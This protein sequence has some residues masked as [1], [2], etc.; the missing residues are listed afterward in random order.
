MSPVDERLCA[1]CKVNPV[2]GRQIFCHQ[3]CRQTAFRLRQRGD[4]MIAA[5]MGDQV[6][7]YADPPYVKL[8]RKFYGSR[9]NYAGEVDHPALIAQ[10]MREVR[11]GKWAGWSL[12]CSTKSL[13][14]LLPLCPESTRVCTWTKPIGVPGTTYGIH[15]ASEQVLVFGG[16]KR[17][18]GVRDWISAQPARGGGD[19]P[20]RKPIAFCRWLFDLMGMLPGDDIVDLF[21]G[22]G[23]VGRSWEEISSYPSRLEPRRS[24]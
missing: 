3:S 7:G 19:L 22:S 6:F 23:V 4:P 17:R 8:S 21:P 20:G 1:W 2:K 14:Y 11:R 15:S 18:P 9:A 10:M 12:S 13:R 24:A 16:R 5:A